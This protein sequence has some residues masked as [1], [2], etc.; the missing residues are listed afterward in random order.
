MHSKVVD[1]LK[2]LVHIFKSDQLLLF[3]SFDLSY[4]AIHT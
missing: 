4:Q 3:L 1:Y 2:E